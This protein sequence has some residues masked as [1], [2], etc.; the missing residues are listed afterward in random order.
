MTQTA[1]TYECN[2]AKQASILYVLGG[3]NADAVPYTGTKVEISD[4]KISN[5]RSVLSGGGIYVGG[6]AT[7]KI[8]LNNDG[9]IQIFETAVD[10]GFFYV[11]NPKA[12]LE[13]KLGTNF[14]HLWAANK[15][16]LIEGTSLLVDSSFAVEC[17]LGN[18]TEKL[19]A[20]YPPSFSGASGGTN[21]KGCDITCGSGAVTVLE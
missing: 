10:G 3:N 13:K 4:S 21:V 1:A 6:S 17:R 16:G 15:G 14:N 19:P 5:G 7:T 2:M 12:T 18:I 20:D 9:I 11:A 8:I